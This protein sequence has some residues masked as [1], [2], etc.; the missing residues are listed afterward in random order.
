M[1]I[2][3]YEVCATN[4]PHPD[5]TTGQH[6]NGPAIIWVKISGVWTC[7]HSKSMRKVIDELNRNGTNRI[8]A[9]TWNEY[10]I[11]S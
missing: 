10:D 11:N 3:E 8:A 1:K 2:G 6:T 7:T 4:Y 9:G 5:I